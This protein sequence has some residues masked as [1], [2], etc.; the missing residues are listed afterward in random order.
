MRIASKLC[1]VLVGFAFS[2][3]ARVAGAAERFGAAGAFAVSGERMTGVVFSSDKSEN[4]GTTVTVNRTTISFLGSAYAGVANVYS[5]PRIAFDFFP[6]NGLSLGGSLALVN[7]SSKT[8]S[9]SQGV[10]VER[11]QGS[12]FGFLFAPRVGYAAMFSPKI[13]IWPRGGITY[14]SLKTESGD[15]TDDSSA[16]A[17]RWALTIEAPLVIS[18][19]PHT[20]I[21]VGPTLD[22]GLGG[23]NKTT[24]DLGATSAESSVDHTGT[25]IGVQAGLG[26]YF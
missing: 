24:T 13:G 10:S 6:I 4:T 15:T 5:L 16:T 19:V 17:S 20:A 26:L 25:D 23:S 9:E 8:K 7:F 22:L 2:G 12:L 3:V 1:C 18:P 11:D 21:Y 14:L